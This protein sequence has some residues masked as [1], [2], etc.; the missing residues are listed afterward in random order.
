MKKLLLY[1]IIFIPSFI[2]GQDLTG[3]WKGKLTQDSGGYSPEY[4]LEVNI[5]QKTKTY[6]DIHLPTLD[7]Q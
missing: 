4:V 7:K 1:L 3:F 2:Y 5:V 6:T